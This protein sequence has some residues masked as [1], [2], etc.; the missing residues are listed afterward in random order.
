MADGS[1][2]LVVCLSQQKQWMEDEVKIESNLLDVCLFQA[3]SVD[4]SGMKNH[5][6]LDGGKLD[7]MRDCSWP[8][9][10]TRRLRVF[11]ALGG[12]SDSYIL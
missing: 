3:E 1:L 6:K 5:R 11:F 9:L 12:H 2:L 4:E 10:T 7:K 8:F